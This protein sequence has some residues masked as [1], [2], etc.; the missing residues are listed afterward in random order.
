MQRKQLFLG[1]WLS[2]QRPLVGLTQ[3]SLGNYPY[4]STPPYGRPPCWL[5]LLAIRQ[6]PRSTYAARSGRRVLVL[7]I[8]GKGGKADPAA[9]LGPELYGKP[10]APW[11]LEPNFTAIC[12]SSKA[13]TG[14]PSSKPQ[15]QLLSSLDGPLDVLVFPTGS[16]TS[17]SRRDCLWLAGTKKVCTSRLRAG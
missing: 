16:L 11:G 8:S 14:A 17:A 12:P 6:E 1:L 9:K 3:L 15:P 2:S 5:L 7:G 13:Q 4:L 10:K